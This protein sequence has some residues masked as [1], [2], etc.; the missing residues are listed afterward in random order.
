MSDMEIILT[1][2][3]AVFVVGWF[4]HAISCDNRLKAARKK[5][6]HLEECENATSSRLNAVEA[7]QS[8]AYTR[9]T[10]LHQELDGY[11]NR[12]AA[13]EHRLT[14]VATDNAKACADIAG[15]V[16]QLRSILDDQAIAR[17]KFNES[18]SESRRK[19]LEEVRSM[20]DMSTA[21][22][23]E[24]RGAVEQNV[25]ELTT[26][27]KDHRLDFD[28]RL[29]DFHKWMIRYGEEIK[30][31]KDKLESK[32]AE[33]VVEEPTVEPAKPVEV[34]K[35]AAHYSQAKPNFDGNLHQ[36]LKLVIVEAV[37]LRRSIAGWPARQSVPEPL[38]KATQELVDKLWN[39]IE[40]LEAEVIRTP[41]TN[42]PLSHTYA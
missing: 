12:V 11:R 21:A 7:W 19:F 9:E 31:I 33:P 14:G 41:A 8:V 3:L 27:L 32:P 37:D 30:A 24:I 28:G 18:Q 13:C 17:T 40:S 1:A 23:D 6:E 29:L 39:A 2:L 34:V 26:L 5:I 38:C 20:L 35:A 42:P 15:R 36:R 4:I 10:A 16:A 22:R 25:Q